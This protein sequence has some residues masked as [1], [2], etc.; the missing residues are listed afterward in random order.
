MNLAPQRSS[1]ILGIKH[2][3][4]KYFSTGLI[5]NLTF[6]LIISYFL[7]FRLVWVLFSSPIMPTSFKIIK[8]PLRSSVYKGLLLFA[9][10]SIGTKINFV[11]IFLR[12]SMTSS[13]CKTRLVF[14]GFTF[15]FRLLILFSRFNI[16]SFFQ[17][18]I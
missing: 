8:L 15:C 10:L 7:T 18:I 3:S 9:D 6:F 5:L 17:A 16:I 14:F 11:W 12:Y 13:R 4:G 2:V 1:C